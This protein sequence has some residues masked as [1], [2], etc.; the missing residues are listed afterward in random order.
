M[1]KVSYKKMLLSDLI[2]NSQKDDLK[3]LE[4]LLKREQKNIYTSLVYLSGNSENVYI[5]KVNKFISFPD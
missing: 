2:T 3:A 5:G 1:S 4:E